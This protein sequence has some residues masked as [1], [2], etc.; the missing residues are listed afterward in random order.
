MYHNNPGSLRKS[1]DLGIE[2]SMETLGNVRSR[3]A[4]CCSVFGTTQGGRG[5]SYVLPKQENSAI[6]CVVTKTS[7]LYC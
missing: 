6:I 2:I 4:L 7:K 1:R 3:N 5:N